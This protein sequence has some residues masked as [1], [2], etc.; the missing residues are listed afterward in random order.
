[1]ASA[2]LNRLAASHIAIYGFLAIA[3]APALLICSCALTFRNSDAGGEVE[4]GVL[5]LR[6]IETGI[7]A[8]WWRDNRSRAFANGKEAKGRENEKRTSCYSKLSRI[9][10]RGSF[11]SRQIYF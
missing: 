2:C 4:Q 9:I 10:H 11:P 7:A 6:R 1:M 3:C 5:S 8:V